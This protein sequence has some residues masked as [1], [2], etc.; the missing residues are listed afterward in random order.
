[1][2]EFKL[3]R[4]RFVWK[5]QWATATVYYQDDVIAFGGKTYICT[6]GHTSQADFFS[7]L[8][9]V[10][11]KWNLVSDGQTWKGD[12]TVDTNYVYNDIVSYGARLYICNTIHTSAATAID[13]T[14]GLEVDLAK[15]DA[16]AEGLDW[17]GDWGVSTRYRIND[18]VKYGGS[19][20]VC[21]TLHISAA[22]AA[23]GLEF[24][25]AKWNV[26]N[27]STEY[28]GGWSAT[29]RYKLNDLVR[30]GA[31]IWIC[32]TP[33]TSAGT[34]GANSANWTKF[35]EGFQYE[36]DWS[37][38]VPY[39]SG[40]VVRYG[41]NQYIS[42]TSNTGSIPFDNPNDWDLFTEGFRFIGDW[43]EDSANQH[44]KVGEVVR[45]GGFTYVCVQDHE[46]EQQ[47]PNANY[48]KLINEG[49][50]WR[51]VWIDDQEYYAGDVVRYGDNSYYCVLG[52]I[53][54]GDDY[55]TETA[56]QPG[57]GAE[58]SRPDLANSGL[59]WN[60]IVVG[61]E[62]SVLTTA[63]DLVYYSGSAPTRLPVGLE[64]QVLKVNTAGLPSW[65]FL[66]SVEDVYFVA[67]HGNDLPYPT[68]GGTLDR[69]FKTIRYACDQIEKG[70]KNPVAQQLI[71]LNRSFIQ[72]EVSS[73][74]RDQV[75]NA[76]GGSIWENFVYDTVKCER[77]VG[78]ILDRIV[79]DMAHGGNLKTRAAAQTFLNALADGPYSTAAENNGTGAY[80]NLIAEGDQ[81][82]AAYNYMLT[83]IGNALSNT[84]P[85]VIYQNVTDDS[86]A[87]IDQ[88]ININITAEASALTR[89]TTLANI[90]INA[91]NTGL[92]SSIPARDVP[93]TLV[94][95][96][97]GKY[98][99]VLPIIV[100][101]YCTIL[102][103]E[104]RS[105]QINAALGTIPVSDSEYTIEMYDRIADVVSDI[106]VGTSVT[107]TTGNTTAQ[108]IDWPHAITAQSTNVTDLVNVMKYQTD[109]LLNTMHSAYLTEPI[110]FIGSAQETAIENIKA[111]INFIVEEVIAYLANQYP[112]LRYG[113]T[114]TRRDARYVID[115]LIYDLTYG[116]NA[117]A[118]KTGLAY[119][120][121]DD[122]TIPQIPA[123]IKTATIAAL[124]FLKTTAQSVAGN[125]S[126]ASPYQATVAQVLTGNVGSITEIANNVETTIAI[127]TT[128]PAV[129]GASVTLVDPTPAN[130][131]NTTTALIGASNALVAAE[132][133][134]I[135][136]VIDDLNVV[137]WHTD[138]AVD[139]T[140][141]TTTQFRIYVGKHSLV[142]TYVSGGT[143]TK[144]NGTVLTISN[145]VYDNVTGYAVV[146][147]STHSLLAG[148][149]VNIE[150][151]TV[152]C[153]NGNGVQNSVFPSATATDGITT[154]IKYLQNKCIRDIRI[155]LKAV[156]YD[157]M[158][159]SN[160]QTLKTA[161]AY[162]RKTAL[163]VYTGNQKTITISAIANA[164]ATEAVA[165][166]AGNSIAQSRI[167]ASSDIFRRIILSA[168]NDGS[169]CQVEDQ[170]AYYAMLQ[171]ERNREFIISEVTSWMNYNYVNFDDFYN[172]ATCARDIGYI[173]DAVSYDLIT[174]SNFA[175]SVAGAAY[176]R[177]Q[178]ALVVSV[179]LKQTIAAIKEAR[180]LTI[181]QT[182]STLHANITTSYAN[183][184]NIFE[185]GLT[186]VPTYTFPDNGTSVADD[187]T[188]AA[189]FI[190][191]RATYVSSI[192]SYLNTNYNAQWVA[193]GAGG[194]ATCQR[195]VG[196]IVDAATFDVL[197][198]GNYQSVIAGDSYY[199]FGTLQIG[200]G[201]E[202]TATLAALTELKS[203]LSADAEAASQAAVESNADDVIAIVTNGAG[204][205]VKVYPVATGETGTIQSTF[206][207]IQ[208]ANITIKTSVT[209]YI[210]NTFS[211]YTYNLALC[212]RD[213]GLYID[214]L[215]YDLKYPGNYK[216][217]YVAR[218]YANAVTGSREEDMFYLRDATGVRDC[219]LFGLNGDLTPAG[220]YDTSRVTAGAYASLDPG[221][222]P[223]DF[224]TW[225]I[226]RSPY[227]QG[228][229][230]FGNA[231]IGQKIDGALHNGGNDSM[232]SNDFTQVI[233]DGIGAWITNNG[234]AELVSVFTYY[235]HIGYLAEAGGRIRA[236]NGNNSYG[237]FGSVAEGT[238]S[239]ELPVTAI[240]D[241]STQYKAT[242]SAVNV[243]QAQILVLEYGHAGND[244]T[245]ATI[246]AFGPGIDE[247]LVADEFRDNAVNYAFVDQNVD[248]DVIIGGSGYVVVSNVAQSG[249]TTSIFL[250]ATDGNLSSA[251]PGMKIY[252]I[253]GSGNGQYAIVNTYN[254]GSKEATVIRESDGIAGWEHVVP[255]TPIIAPNSSSTYQVEPRISFTAPPKSNAAITLSSATT[256]YDVK[257]VETAAQYT[258]VSAT[259]GTGSGLTFDVTRN[260]SKYYLTVNNA[261]TG[262][263]RLD[264][265]TIAG[266]DVGGASTANDITVTLT[267]VNSVTGAVVDYDFTGLAQ[268]GKFLAIGA[269]TTGAL[270]VD[271]ESW[272]VETLPSLGSGNWS[273]IAN[274]LQNDGSST[275]QP[276]AIVI[277]ADGDSTVA[278]SAD[279]DTWLTSSLPGGLAT[280][281]SI[282]IAYGNVVGSVTNRFVVTSSADR[283][284]AYS[285]NGGATWTLTT[286]ALAAIG[287]SS[288]AYGAGKFVA[289]DADS[290][291]AAYSADGIT[292]TTVV[293]PGTSAA[294]SNVVWGNGKFVTLGGT[295]GIMYSLDGIT[296][297]DNALTLPL[298]ATERK[299]AYGQGM[300][301][302]TS[303]NTTQVQY[304]EDGLYWQAYT[305]TTNVTGGY[306]A[307]AFGNP[308]REGKFVILPNASGTGGVYAKIGATTKGRAS[309]ANQQVFEVRITEPGSGYVTAPTITVTDPNNI[310][311]VILVPQLGDGVLGQPT[312]VN[313]GTGFTAAS[314]EISATESNGNANFPQTGT[315]IAVRRLS[316]RPVNGSNVEFASLP[317]AFYKLV[318]TVTFLG[319]NAGTYTGFLQLSPAIAVADVLPE[320]DA[321]E[322]RIRF[323]QARLTG[324]DFLDIGTGGF[325]TTN[326]PNTPINLP[327]QANETQE[328]N[329]GR[330]FYT[331]T[332]QDGNFRVGD[333]FTIEQSTGVATLNADAFNIAGLQE[334]SLGEVTLGGN[335]ASIN[336]FSTDPF[337][338]ANSDTVVPTQRAIKAYIEAQIGGGGAT[339]NVNSV[340]AGDVYIGTDTITTLSGS[341]LN[342]RANVVFS[343][344]VLGLPLA[345]NYFLR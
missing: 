231:A 80:G 36:N 157:F 57:G 34:F 279:A 152:S 323:S 326:Y 221:W 330:V 321:V 17:K 111:N 79:H 71:E 24:D 328:D 9:I 50:R 33:H 53:S 6:I 102:G 129:V 116:G 207:A 15:W 233:S 148:D 336:E 236:T 232:V 92:V 30:Y 324:H 89:L 217:R 2:A 260:G 212:L 43:N 342:I 343:G 3:G 308:A 163:E 273:S 21:N 269:G 309:I 201:A 147:T 166:V 175:S 319:T 345:Y 204:T 113:K 259:G 245:D 140:S 225:I 272:S 108:F 159:N 282:R 202:K 18:F 8:D 23:S 61:T 209:T 300:F 168:T 329:G 178:S 241:N 134:V 340:T 293:L 311:D 196:Y 4:I 58:G 98:F 126:I 95:V 316:T 68:R 131:V 303:D 229:T 32:I 138:W 288:V 74:I 317:G 335:S 27:Q 307:I 277:V 139:S 112:T 215:K 62:Q 47:P 167:T 12:W 31:G 70:T 274:G 218:Y 304:S 40:D 133:T 119:W 105:T 136:N 5:N 103:E 96:S 115:S 144:A 183:I 193:L 283:D 297:Y 155:I 237:E 174:G 164:L 171:L 305:L 81:S 156:R 55:S 222:G 219:S 142:H 91:L 16:Y 177:V 121:G 333:L 270:S 214:A 287:Y 22:T 296:W 339:L 250:A 291:N 150:N 78:F 1:M 203:L 83:L 294:V 180:R 93:Q 258:G 261:G 278:Y 20:Y 52:H 160:W 186:V 228:V 267:T 28:K 46:L 331:A 256:W 320:G 107:P 325:T 213:V 173:V 132:E 301:V 120:D 117:Q 122:N 123:S 251:Y 290:T 198:G 172:S 162:L 337:F 38:V 10:P 11:S 295:N 254:S 41:G 234:R 253:G 51:G 130:G 77:D 280:A 44:Y 65:Q 223:D 268:A 181:L 39:Q 141:L 285:D 266:T 310:V 76:T 14:D 206:T 334:L 227:V 338:T 158:F 224:T 306:N 242:V 154:K 194:Q 125:S 29:T 184:L 197:Y 19:T 146:T 109:Y 64:G 341:V 26:F 72:R 192:S 84:A 82:V 199:S 216:S 104:L 318:N 69:P 286:D 205:V 243:N 86:T 73:W 246:N 189:T 63:G 118:V 75:D 151:I 191:N 314:A 262:Y 298:T 7:D 276:S 170:N 56:V 60:I 66:S 37:P 299:L 264:A 179:Q 182:D 137:A 127:L 190:A 289:I 292:W 114:D 271:G 200:A 247:V 128:G 313:R 100:P 67:E 275:F 255:G 49:F 195:D 165:N 252:I 263:T 187:S 257:Y 244:Y 153:N 99:E 239:E 124:N 211:S 220:V 149:I 249:T 87:I 238:D 110:T 85:T 322:L 248:P 48:W 240:V 35:V 161:H 344:T 185:N 265:V 332:D 42:T 315:F 25:L 226:T 188:T 302:I 169:V 230:T 210:T 88:Y 284:V 101:A 327:V 135:Q 45:L 13:A 312:F 94:R 90:V 176:Y 106:V 145:F 97:T 281:A 143:V 54:E 235:A 208:A 59:Y